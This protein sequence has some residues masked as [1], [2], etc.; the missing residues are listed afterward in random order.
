MAI[1]TPSQKIDL[2]RVP[3]ESLG[4]ATE[5]LA[6]V[7]QLTTRL[8]AVLDELRAL[9]NGSDE[10]ATDRLA[11]YTSSEFTRQLLEHMHLAKRAALLESPTG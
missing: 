4:R 8:W 1:G 9:A 7:E 3:A 5:L 11:R 2:S 6:E 10:D